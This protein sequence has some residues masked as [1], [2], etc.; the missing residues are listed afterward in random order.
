M[1]RTKRLILESATVV[2]KTKEFLQAIRE[3]KEF[4]WYYGMRETEENL[5]EVNISR[6]RFYNIFDQD[7]NFIGYIGFSMEYKY[8]ALELYIIK[9]YRRKGYA[10]ESMMA[11]IKEAFEGN[12]PRMEKTRLSKIVSTIRKEN[13]PSRLLMEKCGFEPEEK[14][15]TIC[16]V[17][18][19]ADFDNPIF[20]VKY[21]ITKER[22]EEKCWI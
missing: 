7:G 18:P 15:S 4:E 20:V 3:A 22:Y 10:Y 8:Y 17:F 1:I 12:I 11:I 6:E 19:E 16:I 5:N 13:E 21:F 14:T 9:A 2:D